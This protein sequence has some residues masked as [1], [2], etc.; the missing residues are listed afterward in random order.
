MK[1]MFI[2]NTSSTW[3]HANLSI[4][5]TTILTNEIE[6][7]PSGNK[8]GFDLLDDEYFTIPYITDTIPNSSSGHQLPK[9]ACVTIKKLD[10]ILYRGYLMGYAATTGFII[11]YNQYQP[12][13][14][15]RTHHVWFDEYNY[16]SSI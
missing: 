15:H 12:F 3:F 8:V 16:R 4:F 5:D 2:I 1:A 7:P 9:N 6:L 11:Y 14:I 10:D 13:V